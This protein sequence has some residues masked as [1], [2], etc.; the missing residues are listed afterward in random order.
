[1]YL[2]NKQPAG[3]HMADAIRCAIRHVLATGEPCVVENDGVVIARYH[4]GVTGLVVE[5]WRPND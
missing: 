4:R 3:K 1:M 5:A 2:I